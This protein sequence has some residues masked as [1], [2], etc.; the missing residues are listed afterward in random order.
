MKTLHGT[1]KSSSLVPRYVLA[2]RW[3]GDDAT[4]AARPWKSSPPP[5]ILPKNLKLGTKYKD[6]TDF[7]IVWRK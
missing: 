5:E 2:T 1:D 6:I 7:P 4:F 3:V